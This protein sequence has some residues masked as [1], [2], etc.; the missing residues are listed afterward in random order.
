M[1]SV[2]VITYASRILSVIFLAGI[3]LTWLTLIVRRSRT[4]GHVS[5]LQNAEWFINIFKGGVEIIR[6]SRWILLL[7]L[8]G[9]VI[10]F[11]ESLGWLYIRL[12]NNPEF[13]ERFSQ[14]FPKPFPS[15]LDNIWRDIIPYLFRAMGGINGVMF[16]P[17]RSPLIIL[18]FLSI[19][20]VFLLRTEQDEANAG[21][22]GL[23]EIERKCLGIF[24][25]LV[26]VSFSLGATWGVFVRDEGFYYLLAIPGLFTYLLA[27]PFGY[28]I[29]LRAMGTADRG[30]PISFRDAL[31]NMERSFRPLFYYIILTTG[32]SIAGYL[33]MYVESYTS[34]YGGGSYAVWQIKQSCMYALLAMISFVPVIVVVQR[35]SLTPALQGCIDLWARH[36]KN[37]AVF[38]AASG[39]LLLPVMLEGRLHWLFA[40]HYS[41]ETQAASLILSVYKVTIGVLIMC[42]MVVFCRKVLEEEGEASSNEMASGVDEIGDQLH[43]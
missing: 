6:R 33:P 24:S 39:V 15:I 25:G 32:I 2:E 26:G 20:M 40:S 19:I 12:K 31:S 29:V 38:L 4:L 42:S 43:G 13:V 30:Q 17:F 1:E 34:Y 14:S 22:G 18:A 10:Q 9:L 8:A 23:S 36:A 11:C 3:T 27:W 16:H 35:N 41:W 28:A 37:A 5:K 7:P 21:L